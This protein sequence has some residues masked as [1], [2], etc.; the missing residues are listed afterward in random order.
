MKQKLL[1]AIESGRAR[2]AELED[3]SVDEPA[4][5]DGKWHPKDHLAHLA[6]WRSRS[7]DLIEATRTGDQPPPSVE[8]EVQNAVIYA[9]NRNRAA[10]GIKRDA[11]A[12][13]DELTEAVRACS[14]ED[15]EKPH[16]HAPHLA[17]WGVVPSDAGHVGVHLMFLHMDSGD[18]ERAE[19]AALWGYEV[20][21]SFFQKPEDR[22]DADYNLAC[23]YA[24][25]DRAAQALA[26]LRASFTAKPALVE[27]ARRDPDLDGIRD[28]IEFKEM[29]AA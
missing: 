13:W 10:D 9:E 11:R 20:E 25:A 23:F 27:L 6:W 19:S 15:L 17:L 18:I 16:P 28:N 8:D 7:A 3:L 26:L 21:T 14:E 2:Q 12:S 24:R 5:P 22:A 4:D 1:R 29:L